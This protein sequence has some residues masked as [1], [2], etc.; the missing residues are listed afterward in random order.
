MT[1]QSISAVALL[2]PDYD[3]AID[4]YVNILGFD[5]LEDTDLGAGKRWVLIRP[6]ESDGT[7]I[8]LARAAN[9]AQRD[10]LG[11]TTGGRVAFFL[12]TDDFERDYANMTARGVHFEEPPRQEA[13]GTVAVWQDP[14]GTRWDLIESRS[15][16]AS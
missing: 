15:T 8:L 4:F 2:V 12:E 11:K 14:F 3:P 1:R 6:H 5:L 7:A 9:D 16:A 10:A 13:Y